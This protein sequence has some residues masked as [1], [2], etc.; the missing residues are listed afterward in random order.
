MIKIGRIGLKYWCGVF[1]AL[2]LL[3]TACSGGDG[4]DEFPQKSRV[5]GFSGDIPLSRVATV[6]A[7]TGDVD[8]IGVFA[9]FG[10]GNFDA[11]TAKPNFMYNQ[12]VNKQADNT[13][14]Y[15]PEKYWPNNNTDKISFF[16]YAP[17][18]D[19]S[20]TPNPYFNG[21]TVSGFPILNYTVP[22]STSN[23]VDL[24]VATPVMNQSSGSVNFK[25]HHTLTKVVIYVKSKDNTTGK[26]VTSFTLIG[27]K[28]GTLTYHASTSAADEGW[29]WNNLSSSTK[30]TFTAAI[31]N[32]PIPDTA[33]EEKKVLVTFYM[34]PAGE[35]S[36]FNVTY[37]YATTDSSGS[38]VTQVIKLENQTLPD[39][40]KWVP[41][42]NIGY[43]I[44]VGKKTISVSQENGPTSWDDDPTE[45]T[46]TGTE[47]SSGS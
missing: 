4:S 23:Q 18:V 7:A 26:T 9:Y 3:L 14:T 20:V 10:S 36:L 22:K 21:N 31:T 27:R 13:W 19:E 33:A 15:T 44:N 24:L 38:T 39:T 11:S 29:Q 40:D 1:F 17:Y 46:V 32:F 43:T 16:A 47:D 8:K 35:G 45:E 37:Q 6:Y 12:C 2:P 42:G 5:V 30:Q 41:G 28:S 25:L 34:L